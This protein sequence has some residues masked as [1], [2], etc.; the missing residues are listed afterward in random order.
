[1]RV[2]KTTGEVSCSNLNPI[3]EGLNCGDTKM[4]LVPFILTGKVSSMRV[5]RRSFTITIYA[6]PETKTS[7]ELLQGS[8][9]RDYEIRFNDPNPPEWL[10]EGVLVEI[11]FGKNSIRKLD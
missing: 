2:L 5:M 7:K 3:K 6:G 10:K 1:M 4:R 11:D 8:P 9:V